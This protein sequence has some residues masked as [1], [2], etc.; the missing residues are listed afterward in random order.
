MRFLYMGNVVNEAADAATEAVETTTDAVQK[1]SHLVIPEFLQGYVDD[2]IGVAI[3][4]IVCLIV[5][6]LVIGAINHM[7]ERLNIEM[8]LQKFIRSIV[9]VVVYFVLALVVA[10]KMGFNTSS[11]VALA[12]VL[13]AA[14]ALAA[15]NSLANLFGGVLLLLTKPFLVGDFITAADIS[16]TVLEIGLLNTRLNTVE[17]KRVSI[18]NGTIAAS[19]ITNVST[20]GCRRVDLK[21]TASYD[22]PIETVKAAIMEAIENTPTA[23]NEPAP[24]FVRVFGY[25]E[26]SIEY[27][28]RVWSENATYWDTYFDLLENIKVYF[29]KHGVE[30]TYNHMNVHM[31]KD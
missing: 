21:I 29:D 13:S 20:E 6:K 9:K 14:F 7:L 23:L 19:T 17:N 31:M 4:L 12:S 27:V 5:G 16:G 30:M 26:S 3:E 25:G 18:P 28:I 22:A 10:N 8:T 11:V 24:P 15:Q 1:V 2:V